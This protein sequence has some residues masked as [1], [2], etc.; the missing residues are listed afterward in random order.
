MIPPRTILA[1]VS[2]SEA[3]RVALVLAARLARQCGAELHV[4][5]AEDPVLSAA[6]DR[7]GIDLARETRDDL[8][9]FIAGAWPAA[10]CVPQ[11]HI[12]AGRVV[13]VILN[14]AGRH[15][16][17]LVVVGSRGMSRAERLVFGSTTDALLRRANRSVLVAPAAWTPPHPDALDLCGVGPLVAVVD[18]SDDP[19][20]AAATAACKLASVLRTSVEIAHVMPRLSVLSRW[21]AHADTAMRDRLA[22]AQNEHERLLCDVERSRLVER[23]VTAGAIPTWLDEAANRGPDRAPVLVLAKGTEGSTR[24]ALHRVLSR[25]TAPILMHVADRHVWTRRRRSRRS[26]PCVRLLLPT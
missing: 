13:D 26:A 10:H 17:D 3:S 7:A 25:A 24:G 22:A 9:R 5:H 8:Q 6:A 20:S 2:F 11:S 15:G 21:S 18:P 14:V 19:S 23:R 12:I 16:A 4:L 1:A